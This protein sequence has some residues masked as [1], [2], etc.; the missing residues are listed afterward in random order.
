MLL[1]A[2]VRR[3]QFSPPPKPPKLGAPPFAAPAL[4]KPPTTV[5]PM[6]TMPNDDGKKTAQAILSVFETGKAEG[7][8]GACAVLEDGA[9]ISYGLHQVTDGGGNLLVLMESY[10]AADGMYAEAVAT[11]F[12]WIEQHGSTHED[13]KHLTPKCVS[14]MEILSSAGDGD[15]IMRECQ[16]TVFDTAYWQPAARQALD[17]AL[18]TP[19]AWCAVYDTCIHSGPGGVGKIRRMFPESPPSKGGSDEETWTKAYLSARYSWLANHDN[20]RVR[21][22]KG[23]VGALMALVEDDNWQLDKPLRVLGIEVR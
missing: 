19:L 3:L 13:P 22:S 21:Q 12:R 7:D 23:R 18:V 1:R 14:L 10:V 4:Q 2:A 6:A 8:Y 5:Y 16:D 11:Y 17:M 20:A 9:G 15:V